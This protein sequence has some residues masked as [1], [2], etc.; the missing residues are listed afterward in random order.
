MSDLYPVAGKK[1]FIGVTSAGGSTPEA[2]A[3]PTGDADASTFSGIDWVEIDGWETHGAIGDA[4]ELIT[5]QLINKARDIKQKGT[6]NASSMENRFA[7]IRTNVGQIAL[8]AAERT[9]RNY[10]FRILGNDA[11][12]TGASP[13]PTT[14]FFIGMVLT[15]RDMGGTANTIEMLE[16][17]IEVNT[18][19]VTVAA[20]T[21]D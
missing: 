9:N 15:A 19:I 8:R 20:A 10:P 11:P 14:Q 2:I 1:L 16:S 13:T 4:A 6:R 5:T 3:L 17:T 18:N 7:T 21:G 12:A